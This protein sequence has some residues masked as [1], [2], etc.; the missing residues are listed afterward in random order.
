MATT[1][2]ATLASFELAVTQD[3]LHLAGSIVDQLTVQ[4]DQMAFDEFLASDRRGANKRR[5]PED[6]QPATRTVTSPS[7]AGS[8][9]SPDDGP[10]RATARPC[11]YQPT[12]RNEIPW[13]SLNLRCHEPRR[14]I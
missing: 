1:V 5:R 6:R 11:M 14:P 3:D 7:S 4:F 9:P 12:T 10:I 13:G 8:A 2:E